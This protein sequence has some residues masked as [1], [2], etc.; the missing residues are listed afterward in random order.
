[1]L[2][3]APA[4]AA[5]ATAAQA[6]SPRWERIAIAALLALFAGM[7]LWL[8]FHLNINWDEYFFLSHV[9]AY[10]DGRLTAPFQ[11]FHVHLFSWLPSLSLSEAD[12]IGMGRIVMLACELVT[13]AMVY[14]VGR[15]FFAPRDAL[16]AAATYALSGYMLAHGMSFRTDP[17]AAMLMMLA[18]WQMIR[19]P[20]RWPSA[21]L[22]GL[23]AAL[24]LLITIK[25]ALFL[26]AFGGAAL[27]RFGKD[28]GWKVMG[29]F[30]LA[31]AA[32]LACYA[33]GWLLHSASLPQ[34]PQTPV[35]AASTLAAPAAASLQKTVASPGIFP[36]WPY[37]TRWITM[38]PFASVLILAGGAMAIMQ[39]ARARR[40]TNL[41]PLLLFAPVMSLLFYRNAY[42]YF[43]P[44]ILATAAICVGLVSQRIQRPLHRYL[45]IATMGL[46]L[47]LQFAY[48][49]QNDQLAQR[50]IAEQVHAIFPK[51]VR[52]ID[53]N[54]MI[55][56]FRKEGLFLSSW[57]IEGAIRSGN[58]IFAPVIANL[59]PPLV[60]AN[61]PYL[62]A[63][64]DA[65]AP[66]VSPPLLPADIDALRENYIQH[67]GPVWVAGKRVEAGLL[68][69]D[70]TI[71]IPGT[72]T[73]ECAGSLWIDGVR[74]NCGSVIEL[75]A[76]PHRVSSTEP[77]QLTLRWG[78]HLHRPRVKPPLG[79]VY[80]GF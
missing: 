35:Q 20:L 46:G 75:S 45:L 8:A 33:L 11:T 32:T 62:E 39:A 23:A 12:Q 21:V 64:L 53:R 29:F 17:P 73:M 19:A 51:P 6:P 50:A 74:R 65:R 26:P 37:F 38:N 67:W 44:F 14:A 70:F 61:S 27:Y 63:A 47:L 40:V 16:L 31:A 59:H 79:P 25:S 43:Y 48:Y 66:H 60:I 68:P 52:Y 58:P 36:A 42:P 28:R 41:V 57:G 4:P 10:L 15:A 30:A 55:P 2:D 7:Q 18:L 5:Y 3:G 56:S 13:L 49:R 76:G 24:A 54:G 71:S 78:D 9:H 22:S 80:H 34:A 77:S 1:M 69:Q 72:Y